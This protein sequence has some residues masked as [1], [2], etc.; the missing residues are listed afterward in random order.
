MKENRRY[1]VGGTAR[2]MSRYVLPASRQE[3]RRSNWYVL[4]K[5]L[6]DGESLFERLALIRMPT[7]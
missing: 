3:R 1:S 4:L 7:L 5:D 2:M 6:V